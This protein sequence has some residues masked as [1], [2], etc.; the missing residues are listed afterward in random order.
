MRG[1]ASGWGG[2]FNPGGPGD[3]YIAGRLA[4][5][6]GPRAAATAQAGRPPGPEMAGA[7]LALAAHLRRTANLLAEILGPHLTADSGVWGGYGWLECVLGTPG[8]RIAGGTDEV[9]R[10]VL[11]ERVLGL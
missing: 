8:I 7:K 5:W 11:A 2:S 3:F 9:L 10:S 6:N 4:E 1:C